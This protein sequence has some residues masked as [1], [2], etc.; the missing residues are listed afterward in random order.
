M[1]AWRPWHGRDRYMAT[2]IEIAGIAS[3]AILG[4]C[5]QTI[6]CS[7]A[8]ELQE[9]RPDTPGRAELRHTERLLPTDDA[10]HVATDP[11]FPFHHCRN[12]Q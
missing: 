9:E 7:C 4:V 11:Q 3:R 8:H 10:T 1:L 6:L 5:A 2:I 12:L